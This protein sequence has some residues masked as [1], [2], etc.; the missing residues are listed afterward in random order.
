MKQSVVSANLELQ[1]DQLTYAMQDKCCRTNDHEQILRPFP[2]LL[3]PYA[4]RLVNNNIHRQ[5]IKESL[6]NP[7]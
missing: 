4:I 1:I 6:I 7:K 2:G 5:W 3:K